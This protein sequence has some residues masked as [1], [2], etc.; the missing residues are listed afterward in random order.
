V[1]GKLTD[2]QLVKLYLGLSRDLKQL[3][4]SGLPSHEIYTILC[5]YLQNDMQNPRSSLCN[6]DLN[7]KAKVFTVLNTLFCASDVYG[8]SRNNEI[9]FVYQ[10][11]I[12]NESGE[13]PSYHAAYCPADDFLF[14]WL[15]LDSIHHGP[16]HHTHYS[17]GCCGGN[18]IHGHDGEDG[19]TILFILLIL[20]TLCT[21]A[22]TL[23][24][25]YYLLKLT[26]DS[27]ERLWHNEGTLQAIIN[28]SGM[29]GGGL[30]SGLAAT[31]FL[32]APLIVFALAAGLSNPIGWAGFA[33]VCI[34]IIGGALSGFLSNQIQ[35]AIIKKMNA[36]ALDP[37]DPYRFRLSQK[38]EKNLQDKNLDPLKV[39]CAIIALHQEIGK[40]VPSMLTRLFSDKR[41]TQMLLDQVRQLRRGE[42]NNGLITIITSNSLL[43]FNLNFD[44]HTS[45]YP[46]P[47]QA[48]YYASYP[49]PYSPQ[50][51]PPF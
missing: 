51:A 15:L 44:Q 21:L 9:Q 23:I 2:S 16:G 6:L 47:Q 43:H 31:L 25:A 24:A 34:T 32:S 14:T 38:E 4:N 10:Y 50:Y 11:I 7:E 45:Y 5:G 39:K 12:V 33:L 29:I 3:K 19:K 1:N 28:L 46:Q 13:R 18:N 42:T 36:D 22:V 20:L 30:A 26:L 27:F 40:A 35:G 17:G 8:T 48:S 41:N 49:P 37:D